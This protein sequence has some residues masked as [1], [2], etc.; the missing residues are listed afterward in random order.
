MLL[1]GVSEGTLAVEVL[2]VGGGQ[3]LGTI[4]AQ[5][6]VAWVHLHVAVAP[7]VG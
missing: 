2:V 3:A 1:T 7:S 4:S 5:V 6:G